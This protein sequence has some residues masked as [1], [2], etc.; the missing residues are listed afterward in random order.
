MEYA[1]W[2]MLSTWYSIIIV[3]VLFLTG[4]GG[5]GAG[6]SSRHEMDGRGVEGG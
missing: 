2:N 1:A 6:R 4:D 3:P 5:V